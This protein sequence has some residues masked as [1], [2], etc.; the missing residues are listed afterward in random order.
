MRRKAITTLGRSAAPVTTD[1]Y[2]LSQRE[3]YLRLLLMRR[4]RASTANLIIIMVEI[5]SH[6]NHR[7]NA[8][9]KVAFTLW[10]K[11]D[12]GNRART[13]GAHIAVSI[14][15]RSCM[16]SCSEEWMERYEQLIEK[17]TRSY[18]S[19][20]EKELKCAIRYE[21]GKRTVG[22]V[23]QTFHIHCGRMGERKDR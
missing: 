8:A 5:K 14:H 10:V 2:T 11:I 13:N 22:R 4:R 23:I 1:A 19:F 3:M 6:R 7:L 20:D 17:L 15:C 9:N 16:A 18:R 21:F 12:E